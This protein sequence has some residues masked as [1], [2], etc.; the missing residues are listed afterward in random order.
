M[1]INDGKKLKKFVEGV[2]KKG[3]ALRN[4]IQTA[5]KNT[6]QH[7]LLHG[8]PSLLN[9]LIDGVNTVVADNAHK[10]WIVE[11]APWLAWKGESNGFAIKPE[12]RKV[13][14]GDDTARANAE[15]SLELAKPYWEFSPPKPFAGMNVMSM[16]HAIVKKAESMQAKHEAGEITDEEWKKVD[17]RGLALVERMIA[18]V[19]SSEKKA[20]AGNTTEVYDAAA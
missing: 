20:T 13:I 6:A 12:I 15:E 9:T 2:I 8:D 17:L 4:D 7:A 1:F 5:L 19:D 16:L 14:I 11:F 10:K 3:E 18:N